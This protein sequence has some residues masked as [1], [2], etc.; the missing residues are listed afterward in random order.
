M[1]AEAMIL[2]TPLQLAGTGRP[3]PNRPLDEARFEAF[4]RS[5][6]GG[7]WSYIFRLTGDAAAADD[8]LQKAFFR[9]IRSNPAF[10]DDDHKRRW[11][12][13]TATNLALDHFRETKRSRLREL[14]FFGHEPAPDAGELRHDMMRV[15]GELKPRERALL[16]LAHVEESDHEEIGEALGVKSGS[17]KVLLFRARKR[18]GELLTKR[19]LAP[20]GRR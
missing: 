3:T 19:G 18:L 1:V 6:A 7:L 4:Y 9:F 13:R 8:L 15:F 2:T 20:E 5:T 12:Y 17:V 11:I 16:W 10:A 14:P